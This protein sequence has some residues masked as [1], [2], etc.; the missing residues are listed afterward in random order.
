M[1]SET[2]AAGVPMKR[3]RP[4]VP[5]AELAVLKVL[6]DRSPATIREIA[7]ELYPG[8]EVAHY[9][10][11]QKLLERLEAK[12]CVKRDRS[13][14]AHVFRPAVGRDDLIDEELRQIADRLCDGSLVPVLNQLVRRASL[15]R[16][17]REELKKLLDSHPRKTT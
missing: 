10:T 16:A 11:V 15:S 7:D 14:A 4:D 1:L 17:Q 6:W 12:R 9:A 13:A 2:R 5:D 3:L 8:G